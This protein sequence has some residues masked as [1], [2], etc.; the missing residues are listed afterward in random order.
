[1]SSLHISA[2]LIQDVK[3]IVPVNAIEDQCFVAVKRPLRDFDECIRAVMTAMAECT[4][5]GNRRGLEA[6]RQIKRNGSGQQASRSSF[7]TSLT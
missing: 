4:P 6:G 1:M 3:S 7:S 2:S 5:P